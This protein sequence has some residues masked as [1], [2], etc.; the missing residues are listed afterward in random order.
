VTVVSTSQLTDW[1][2]TVRTQLE[3]ALQSEYPG[4]EVEHAQLTGPF[5]NEARACIWIARAQIEPE[6]AQQAVEVRIRLF[7]KW[8]LVDNPDENPLDP[9]PLEQVPDVVNNALISIQVSAGLWWFSIVEFETDHES[10][11]T[12]VGI[13]ARREN[14]F[15]P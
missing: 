10:W 5:E 13:L 15:L 9:T 12:E 14:P 3:G 11:G 6:T 4:I 2:Q 1:L 7:P 8:T